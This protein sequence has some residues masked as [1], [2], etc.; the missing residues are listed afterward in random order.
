MA[1]LQL[2]PFLLHVHAESVVFLFLVV[3]HVQVHVRRS[4]CRPRLLYH[5]GK[6]PNKS[7]LASLVAVAVRRHHSQPLLGLSEGDRDGRYR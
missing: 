4:S 6:D 7:L 1:C 5:R 3:P 2:R